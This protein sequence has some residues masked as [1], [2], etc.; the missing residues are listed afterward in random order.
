MP[1]PR[2]S[3]VA[4]GPGPI[5]PAVKAIIIANVGVF[6]V[7]FALPEVVIGFAGLSP[8]AVIERGWIWQPASYL[9]VHS[10]SSLMHIL[11]NMLAVWMFGVDLERRWGTVGFTK[12]YF[13]SR[14]RRRSV[15]RPRRRCAPY[16]WATATYR[17]RHRRRVGRRVRPV[18]GLGAALSA[19]SNS[20]HVHLPAAGAHVRP[21]HR[22]DRVPVRCRRER[23]GVSNLAHLGGLLAVMAGI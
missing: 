21:D 13:V 17:G 15:H 10:P 14:R 4:F 6:L 7:T 22:R 3:S 2:Y 20:V 12:F 11:F 23:T 16:D 19:P 18:D 1:S 8:A 9:F 5:T